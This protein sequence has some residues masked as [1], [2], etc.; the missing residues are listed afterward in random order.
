MSIC[1][2]AVENIMSICSFV[3]NYFAGIEE[4]IYR[5]EIGF[6]EI[7]NKYYRAMGPVKF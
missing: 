2:S 6:A 4:F 5:L 7:R 3:K 1:S